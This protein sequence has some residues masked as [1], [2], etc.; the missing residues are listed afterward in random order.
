MRNIHE[1]RLCSVDG[2]E[3]RHRARGLC[4]LHYDKLRTSGAFGAASPCLVWGCE[5]IHVAQGYCKTHYYRKRKYDDPLAGRDAQPSVCVADG[6]DAPTI[7]KGC[8][9]KHYYRNYRRLAAGA[10][11]ALR[12]QT[13]AREMDERAAAAAID[14]KEPTA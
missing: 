10:E 13:L 5:G 8:C 3:R 7:A 4:R 1:P 11:R 9:S 6:C 14:G 2:C 12:T